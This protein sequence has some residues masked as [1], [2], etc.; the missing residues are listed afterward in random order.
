MYGQHDPPFF[1]LLCVLVAKFPSDAGPNLWGDTASH[2]TRDGTAQR[3]GSI[4]HEC[5]A[6]SPQYR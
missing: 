1:T 2:G 6:M 3:H 4:V 5:N